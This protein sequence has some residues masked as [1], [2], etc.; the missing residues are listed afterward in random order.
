MTDI[1]TIVDLQ[2]INN[3][4]GPIKKGSLKLKSFNLN[5]T[6][7]EITL[8]EEKDGKLVCT[9]NDSILQNNIIDYEKGIIEFKDTIG[10]DFINSIKG[11]FWSYEELNFTKEDSLISQEITESLNNTVKFCKDKGLYKPPFDIVREVTLILEELI[12]CFNTEEVA[13]GKTAKDIARNIISNNPVFREPITDIRQLHDNLIDVIV[14]AENADTHLL[15]ETVERKNDLNYIKFVFA[16]SL[17]IVTKA[18]L[19]KSNKLD[20]KGK[21]IKGDNF[22]HPILPLTMNEALYENKE[23]NNADTFKESN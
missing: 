15:N 14:F 21:V 18:N 23:E 3:I 2:K 11:K 12:E 19:K 4:K 20:E 13:P 8:F 16:K 1:V 9:L 22:V 6:S 7:V 5:D 10:F 17:N